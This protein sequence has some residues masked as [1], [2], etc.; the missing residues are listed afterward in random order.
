MNQS[1]IFISYS[2]VNQL[3]AHKL[4]D[5]LLAEGYWVWMDRRLK[6]AEE[7]EPQIDDNLRKSKTFVV[8]ISSQ[9]VKSD[10]VK[11]EGSM[12]FAL[13]QLIIPVKI[14]P[15]GT[16]SAANLPIWVAKIQLLDLIE[17]ATDYA[18][19]FQK[20]KQLLGKPLPIR[21]H[22]EEMLLHYKNSGMLLDEVALA[23]IDR[24]Y[25]ELSLTKDEKALAEKLIEESRR[26][27][28]SY[29]IRYDKLE[30]DFE[31]AKKN[32]SNLNERIKSLKSDGRFQLAFTVLIYIIIFSYLFF[33]IY[34][35]LHFK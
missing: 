13:N 2:R 28:D 27:L 12:A 35:A 20:L 10:W 14:E 3:F 21:Q 31:N 22:L 24:H 15:F 1:Q 17:G 16:Y 8:L 19:H 25:D 23:L 4:Y 5:V 32:I 18:D 29:W 33:V 30:K 34:I 26:K 7:W 6:P 11:H 9:S